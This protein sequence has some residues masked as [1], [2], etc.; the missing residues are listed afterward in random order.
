MNTVDYD[1]TIVF[2]IPYSFILILISWLVKEEYPVNY[3]L[4]VDTTKKFFSSVHH[5]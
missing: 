1:S 4:S 2:L 5:K 3:V